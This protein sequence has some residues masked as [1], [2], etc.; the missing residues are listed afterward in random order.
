MALKPG[1]PARLIQPE[2][3]GIVTDTR[4][5][6]ERNTFECLLEYQEPDGST[7]KRWLDD[8]Q[9]EPVPDTNTQEPA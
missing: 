9:I 7:T 8:D 2:V 5:V 4:W 1:T 3:R 6:P